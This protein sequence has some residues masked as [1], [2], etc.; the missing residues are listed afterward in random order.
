LNNVIELAENWR[1]ERNEEAIVAVDADGVGQRI[2][3][4]LYDYL[5]TKR[6]APHE[7]VRFE[8][9]SVYFGQRAPAQFDFDT[10]ADEAHHHLSRWLARGGVFRADEKLQREMQ[11][12]KWSY[13]SRNRDGVIYIVRRGPP[14]FG[15][16]SYHEA[17]HRSP[18]RLDM[19]RVFAYAAY[20][21]DALVVNDE[22]TEEAKQDEEMQFTPVDERLAFRTHMRRIKKGQFG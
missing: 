4:R 22:R 10:V 20:M 7:K 16:G 14:K 19:L 18:D 9:V 6:L 8:I 5:E 12:S 3:G 17:L 15:A 21:K 13:V 1:N 11:H 2:I